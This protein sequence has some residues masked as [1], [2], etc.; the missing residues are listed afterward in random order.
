MN[1]SGEIDPQKEALQTLLDQVTYGRIDRRIALRAL[2]VWGLAAA[3]LPG[4]E[5]AFAAGE[6]QKKLAANP[7]DSFDV[8]VIGGGSAGAVVAARASEN[9]HRKVLLLEAGAP[10]DADSR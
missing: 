2:G 5:E 7:V 6:T 8:I 1:K 4:L 10:C 3:G 9:P